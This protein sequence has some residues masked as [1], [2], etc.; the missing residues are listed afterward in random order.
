MNCLFNFIGNIMFYINQTH[1]FGSSEIRSDAGYI[2]IYQ[3]RDT[4]FFTV[5]PRLNGKVY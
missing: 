1:K 2:E 4:T 3:L 5:Q